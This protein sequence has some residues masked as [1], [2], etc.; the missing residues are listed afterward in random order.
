MIKKYFLTGL[1]VLLPLVITFWIIALIVNLLTTPFQNFVEEVLR[2]YALADSSFHFFNQLMLGFFSKLLI[3]ITLIGGTLL[4]GLLGR[5][6]LTRYIIKLS[7]SVMH[8]IPILNKVYK[9]V[10]DVITSLLQ[11]SGQAFNQV[12]L[13]PFPHQKSFSIGLITSVNEHNLESKDSE[14]EMLSVFIPATPN[15]TVGFLLLLK[16][17]QLVYLDMKVDEALKT[18][19]SC[20]IVFSQPVSKIL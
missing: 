4:I 1:A 5:M 20:G 7:D 10:Q 19:I 17:S 2:H 3:L 9:A 16:K 6:F 15:P 12:V 13:V 11:E 18:I 14:D 8:R